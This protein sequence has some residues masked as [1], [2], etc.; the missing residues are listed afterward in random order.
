MKRVELNTIYERIER[1][2]PK[3]IALIPQMID[4]R[5]EYG[6]HKEDFTRQLR[7][8]EDLFVLELTKMGIHYE[9]L[10]P[11][12]KP[13]KRDWRA[14]DMCVFAGELC[15]QSMASAGRL[16]KAG[17][18]RPLFVEITED[19]ASSQSKLEPVLRTAQRY[20]ALDLLDQLVYLTK[21]RRD[22]RFVEFDTTDRPNSQTFVDPHPEFTEALV[23][24]YRRARAEAGYNA[25]EFI[26]L[27]HERHGYDTAMYL[28]H[29]TQPSD[30]FTALWER[31]R[32]DLT[33][34]AVVLRPK[35]NYLF[36][37]EDRL[38]TYRRLKNYEYV[39]PNDAWNPD[40]TPEEP[41]LT[42]LASDFE[43]PSAD[44]V[45][46]VIYRR[47]R[48]TQ[49]ARRVKLLHDYKCQVC[50]H[51]IILRDGTRYAEAHHIK[52][53]G[54]T[55]SGPDVI[56]NI[57]CLCPNH[58]AELDYGV[59]PISLGALRL[60]TAHSVSQEFIDYHNRLICSGGAEKAAGAIGLAS[61][62]AASNTF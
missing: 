26:Q 34:E 17:I 43:D 39:F 33:V 12:V 32:L 25:H 8:R 22:P 3:R 20:N 38:A 15:Y 55:H 16:K 23:D 28:I 36:T 31:K 6:D 19:E 50:D 53:L 9:L 7:N 59:R 56:E 51:V 27:L 14:F 30:G 29:S 47:L 61:P 41:Q 1:L 48:D 42:P 18:K 40:S 44:R 45:A 10:S 35:W 60:H 49:L 37:K 57:L 4:R 11:P 58:H 13:K 46:T 54:I 52:P 24:I 62:S 2:E 5:I 21:T